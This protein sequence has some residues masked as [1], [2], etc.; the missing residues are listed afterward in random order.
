MNSDLDL[1]LK[2]LSNVL[3]ILWFIV[4][5][6]SH[7]TAFQRPSASVNPLTKSIDVV[8]C[9]VYTWKNVLLASL[10]VTLLHTFVASF[11][12][13]SSWNLRKNISW[14]PSQALVLG[15]IIKIIKSY[16]TQKATVTRAHKMAVKL[17]T[18][19]FFVNAILDPHSSPVRGGNAPYCQ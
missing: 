7:G 13:I 12:M 15:N 3:F 16:K 9:S 10:N 5:Y 2:K 6:V 1:L 11:S 17:L 14:W 4:I 19:Q 18:N 8:Y